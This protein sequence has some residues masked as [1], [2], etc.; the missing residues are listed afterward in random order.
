MT[1]K[2]NKIVFFSF[3]G[4][5]TIRFVQKLVK[6]HAFFENLCIDTELASSYKNADSTSPE[7]Q[8]PVYRMS[9]QTSSETEEEVFIGR[10][11]EPHHLNILIF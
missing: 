8:L 3:D 9:Q 4:I 5:F 11:C 1:A 2:Q 6:E 10:V 7:L